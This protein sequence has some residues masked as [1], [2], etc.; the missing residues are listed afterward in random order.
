M[1]TLVLII[2][3][4]VIAFSAYSAA[5]DVRTGVWTADIRESRVQLS[6]FPGRSEMKT[7]GRGNYY[8]I[9]GFAVPLAKLVGLTPDDGDT[10]FTWRSAAG[11][12]DFDGHF[13]DLQG[14]GHF[15]FTPS[16][17]FVRDMA[18]LGYTDFKEDSLLI[19]TVHDLTPSVIRE[20]KSMGYQPSRRELD[21]VA[22]YRITPEA[23]REYA[24]HGYP[25]L[26]LRELVNLRVGN[27]DADYI[28]AIRA[29]GYTNISAHD[30]ADMAILGVT[31][32]YIRDLRGAGLANLT[33]RDLRD[34]RVGNITSKKIEG[35]RLAGYPNLTTRELQEFGIQNVTPEFIESMRKAGLDN[36]PARKMIELRIFNITPEYIRQMNE[37]G[38]HDLKKM[39]ELKQTGAAEVLLKKRS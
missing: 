9:I 8:N 15:R 34:L 11:T 33:S 3:A 25:S 36:I 32:L 2:L 35:Y 19:Y 6:I 28:N 21:D 39:L 10:K 24:R 14:A 12:I 7:Y 23:I 31:P 29:L 5:T 26:T 20:L 1:K 30:L 16:D 4:A 13:K 17:E 22:F 27:V 37:I 38:V 18:Q